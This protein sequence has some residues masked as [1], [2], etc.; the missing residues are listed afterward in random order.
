MTLG[1]HSFY[2]FRLAHAPEAIS[3]RPIVPVEE[4]VDEVATVKLPGGWLTLMDG[5][6]R[7]TLERNVIG[8]FLPRQRWFGAKAHV[9]ES[10][11]IRDW[12][13]LG[14]EEALPT[15]LTVIKVYY[16]DAG[17]DYYFLP[18]SIAKG[19][20]AENLITYGSISM[21]ARLTSQDGEGVLYDGLHDDDACRRV[22]ASIG[23]SWNQRTQAGAMGGLTTAAWRRLSADESKCEEPIVRGA[24]EQSNSTV[25]FGDRFILKLFRRLE[26]GVN[27]DFELGHFLTEQARF[28]RVPQTAGALE[29]RPQR[30]EGMTLAQL[31]ELVTNQGNAWERIVDDL[32]QYFEF[33]QSEG[34]ALPQVETDGHTMLEQVDQEIPSLVWEPIGLSLQAAATLGRRTAE[35][36]LALGSAVDDPRFVPEPLSSQDLEET[37][38][39]GRQNAEQTFKLLEKQLER[40]P[41]MLRDDAQRVLELSPRIIER[42]GHLAEVRP[43]GSKLRCHGDYHLGQ[44]LWVENDFVILDFEGEP[45]SPLEQRRAKQSPLKDV[46]GMVRSFEYATYSALLD[47]T[48]DR[49]ND[50]ALLE[51]WARQWNRWVTTK[52]LGNYFE[53]AGKGTFLPTDKRVSTELLQFFV[54]EK[55]LYELRYELNNRPEW[56]VIPLLGLSQMASRM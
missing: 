9:I 51:P 3:A 22:L 18:L 1:P 49:P 39:R 56:M 31:Q 52:F 23:S 29:Y 42:L 21:L 16:A 19:Q 43:T 25:I 36:H 47:F 48:Q 17:A 6:V 55:L 27:P 26:P 13:V 28:E 12:A 38:Q 5:A 40:V 4:E 35:M 50:F 14:K 24:A 54:L 45:A 34:A 33:A 30:R 20:E 15:F 11:S 53:Y 7:A 46:A 8:K 44:V 2:S 32:G 37:S 10:V 41:A